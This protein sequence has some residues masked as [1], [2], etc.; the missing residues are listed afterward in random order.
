MSATAIH[1][2]RPQPWEAAADVDERRLPGKYAND[3][4]IFVHYPTAWEF[5]DVRGF[6]PTLSQIVAKPGA[7]GVTQ[8]GRMNK[9]LAGSIEK[10]GN[11][12]QPEDARLGPWRKHVASYPT[13]TGRKHW[14]FFTM[15]YDILPGGR[16]MLRANPESF[17]DFRM[18]LRDHG[19]VA[20]MEESVYEMLLA[21]E[22]KG[23]ERASNRGA[24]KPHLADLA[25]KRKARIEA[26]QKAWGGPALD[27]DAP[28]GT[29][30]P[31][32]D[33]ALDAEE[34][35]TMAG[36]PTPTGKTRVRRAEV[37]SG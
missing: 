5:D 35:A 15:R 9:A 18:Y 16:V 33:E 14:C 4:F 37:L 22:Q 12:I 6:L 7:N 28:I 29:L 32:T 8:D 1:L 13:A 23:Y 11:P 36:A 26:M 3:R 30:A 24:E 31:S 19:V 17:A 20:P 2:D 21:M 27:T 10:G 34:L 25:V